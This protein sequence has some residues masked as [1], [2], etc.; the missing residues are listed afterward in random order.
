ML[1]KWVSVFTKWVSIFTEWVSIFT[2]WVSFGKAIQCSAAAADL[3][4]F[5]ISSGL[6]GSWF[7]SLLF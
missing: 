4:L 2:K 5:L 6:L 1:M 7:H 3:N